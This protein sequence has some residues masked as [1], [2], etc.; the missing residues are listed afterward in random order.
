MVVEEI[1]NELS[2]NP[3]VFNEMLGNLPSDLITWK[4]K[5]TD[6]CILEIVCHLVDEE[7]EDFRARVKHSLETPT[8]PLIP[9]HPQNWPAE[10]G[11]LEQDFEAVLKQFTRE[12]NDSILW[13]IKLVNPFWDSAIDHPELG[14][15]SALS[16]LTNWLAHDYHHIRQINT[17]K[18]SYLKHNSGDGLTYAGKW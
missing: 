6:W 4:S 15:I 1:I 8:K 5:P 18:H 7:K 11:Y 9:I 2:R 17:I 10:R 12:R 14:K 16:F 13:L 3:K